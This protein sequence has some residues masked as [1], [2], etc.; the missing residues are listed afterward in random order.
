ML[1]LSYTEGQLQQSDKIL[2]DW[3]A[4]LTASW[5]KRQSP[6][7]LDTHSLEAQAYAQKA[8]QN[9]KEKSKVG[10]SDSAKRVTK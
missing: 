9:V 2:Q 3:Q 4:S 10:L 7:S 1:H 8:P 5:H 6:D